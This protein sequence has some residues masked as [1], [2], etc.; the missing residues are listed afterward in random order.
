LQLLSP[1]I[2]WVQQAVRRYSESS[3]RMGV[4]KADL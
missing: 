3:L 4:I 2:S 1:A